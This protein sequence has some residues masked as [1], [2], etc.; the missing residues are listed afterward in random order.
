MPLSRVA[1]YAASHRGSW[2]HSSFGRRDVFAHPHVRWPVK[3]RPPRQSQTAVPAVVRLGGQDGPVS[4]AEELRSAKPWSL[5]RIQPGSPGAYAVRRHGLYLLIHASLTAGKD[6]PPGVSHARRLYGTG[7]IG[8]P[9]RALAAIAVTGKQAAGSSPACPTSP[10]G[11]LLK[12]LPEWEGQL[13]SRRV[14]SIWGS[15]A[16]GSA[17]DLG[18]RGRRFESGL[19]HQCQSHVWC[20]ALGYAQPGRLDP[21]NLSHEILLFH[22][23]TPERRGRGGR[24]PTASPKAEQCASAHGEALPM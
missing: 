11:L 12:T 24:N 5:V 22:A 18:S 7:L 4:S 1:E 19:S 13:T 17:R 20:M 3:I 9:A 23:D 21:V 10:H 6:R 16:D 8:R 2:C 14:R 15:S